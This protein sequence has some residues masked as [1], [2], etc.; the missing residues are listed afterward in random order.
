LYCTRGIILYAILHCFWPILRRLVVK[1]D[2][3]NVPGPASQS[4][5]KGSLLE[6]LNINAWDFHKELGQKY[7]AVARINVFLGDKRLYFSDPKALYHILV[8]DQ[9]L[10]ELTD[11]NVTTTNILLGAG[12][13]STLGENHRKQR[14]MLNPL[15]SIP[16]MRQMI[17]IFYEV[18]HK[19]SNALVSTAE[20]GSQEIDVLGW[21]TRTALELV[22]QSGLGCSLDPLA[23]DLDAHPYSI[24]AKE[25]LPLVSTMAFIH[26]YLPMVVKI[27]PPRFR[28]FIVDHCLPFKS[29]KRLRDIVDIMHET[30]VEILEAKER[31]LQEGDEAVM[32]Q[33]GRGQDIIAF[34]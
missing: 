7:N 22:A 9:H 34:S 10:F 3:D 2:L 27:C 19:L 4:F 17:P 8:K 6:V 5:L 31:A 16:H 28:R 32:K 15:F 29:A 20:N 25:M 11:S 21:F 14:K 23:D 24:A 12:L 33:I 1:T 13:L 30:S 18:T 26:D